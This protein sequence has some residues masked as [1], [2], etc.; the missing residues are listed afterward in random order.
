[1]LFQTI[2]EWFIEEENSASYSYFADFNP[3]NGDWIGLF[4]EGFSS[5]DDYIVYEY[6]NRGRTNNEQSTTSRLVAETI[7]FSETALKLHGMYRLIYVSQQGDVVSILGVS[8]PF[9]G[10]RRT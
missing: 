7:Y 5:L 6:V 4:P 3:T 10:H 9:P 8:T 2:S 1:M